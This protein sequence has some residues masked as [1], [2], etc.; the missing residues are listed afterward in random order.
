[1]TQV[2]MKMPK[3]T[4]QMEPNLRYF[5]HFANCKFF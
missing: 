2:T 3:I 1:M 4:S 5:R